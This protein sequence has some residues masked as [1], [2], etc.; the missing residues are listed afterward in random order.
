MKIVVRGANWIGDAV[1]SIPALR[2]LRRTFPEA[3]I[4]LYTKPWS[5]GIFQDA[6]F[7][8]RILN[9]EAE[10]SG[11]RDAMR[12]AAR[13]RQGG[14]DL[15]LLFTNSFQTAAVA[16]LAGV[17]QRLGYSREGRG[18]LLSHPISPPAWRNEKHQSF[19]YLNLV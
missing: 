1:M 14:Y 9:V 11:I 7:I 17:K 6:E 8:D 15:A 3:N 4:T 2:A 13:V 19:Y 10:G 5:E 12:E 16:R 18:V